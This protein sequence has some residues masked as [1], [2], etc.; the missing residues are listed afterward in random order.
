MCLKILILF[1]LIT[2]TVSGIA[3]TT[4]NKFEKRKPLRTSFKK[5]GMLLSVNKFRINI[6]VVTINKV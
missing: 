1:D 6:F 4:N 2:L 5:E 3:Q